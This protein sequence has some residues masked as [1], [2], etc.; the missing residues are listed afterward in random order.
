MFKLHRRIFGPAM[1]NRYL[2]QMTPRI[3]R[4]AKGLVELWENKRV[5]LAKARTTEA[6]AWSAAFEAATDLIYWTTVRIKMACTT[7][8][9]YSWNFIS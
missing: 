1:T 3:A 2:S 6:A 9:L 8:D 4:G 7:L 5:A